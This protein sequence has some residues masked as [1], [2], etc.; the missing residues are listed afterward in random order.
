MSWKRFAGRV[1]LGILLLL[2]I[3]AIAGYFYLESNGFRQFAIREIVKRADSATGGKAQI[4]ALSFSLSTLTA[5]LY[6]ITLR[7]TES[8]DLPPLLHAD[9]LTVQLQIVSALHRKVAL[10]ELLIARPVIHI[11]INRQEGLMDDV[12]RVGY[13]PEPSI[14]AVHQLPRGRL[15]TDPYDRGEQKNAA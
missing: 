11:E 14:E 1:F 15:R 7:G 10:R 2:I 9:E 8:R 12:N 6:N 3:V 5:H 4:G 13:L